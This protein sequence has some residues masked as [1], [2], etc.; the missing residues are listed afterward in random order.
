MY[1]VFKQAGTPLPR[2]QDL[3]DYGFNLEDEKVFKND[4]EDLC[5]DHADV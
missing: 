3:V 4:D 2:D 5:E 1:A